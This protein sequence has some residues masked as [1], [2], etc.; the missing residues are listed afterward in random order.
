MS[1]SRAMG[2]EQNSQGMSVSSGGEGDFLLTAAGIRDDAVVLLSNDS[3]DTWK[4]E[5]FS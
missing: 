1:F 4:K 2:S 3:E 5:M